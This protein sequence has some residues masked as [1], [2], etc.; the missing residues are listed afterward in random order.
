[1]PSSA[2][3]ER[4]DVRLAD[5]SDPSLQAT[6]VD[7]I[8]D[9]ARDPMGGGKPLPD[10]TREVLGERLASFPQHYVFLAWDGDSAIGVATCFLGFSTFAAKPLINIHDLAVKSSHRGLGIG[11]KLIQAVEST[12]LELGCC[13]LTLEVLVENERARG[14][15]RKVGFQ[16]AAFN[17]KTTLF[18]AKPLSQ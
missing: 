17:N 10:A 12:A 16:E 4:I 1:M 13:K 3:A 5:L 18:L 8:D 7:L 11:A 6:V 2:S 15:Y 14:L 9:Y